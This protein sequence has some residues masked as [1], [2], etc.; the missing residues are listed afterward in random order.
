MFKELR[1]LKEQNKLMAG[2]GKTFRK[3]IPFFKLY[4]LYVKQYDKSQVMIQQLMQKRQAFKNFIEMQEFCENGLLQSFLIL[5]VQ[6]VPRYVL[7]LEQLKQISRENEEGLDDI[8]WALK[9]IKSV[10]TDINTTVTNWEARSKVVAIQAKFVGNKVNLLTPGRYFIKDGPL[11]KVYNKPGLLKKD[12][13]YHFFLFNDLLVYAQ[14]LPGLE[15]YNYKHSISVL[16]MEVADVPD[17]DKADGLKFA[18]RVQGK[19]SKK[20]LLYAQTQ[21]QKYDWLSALMPLIEKAQKNINTLHITEQKAAPVPDT[22]TAATSTTTT[23]AGSTTTGT[24]K[25]APTKDGKDNSSSVTAPAKSVQ[26][27]SQ[28][29]AFTPT[30]VK[31]APTAP[32]A[33]TTANTAAPKAHRAPPPPRKAGTG[34]ADANTT[35]AANTS[36]TVEATP[37]ESSSSTST[38][39]A[40]VVVGKDQRSPTTTDRIRAGTQAGVPFDAPPI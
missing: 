6:R 12:N 24:T 30:T 11:M 18:F 28:G 10:A 35:T 2:L 33:N 29:Q 37:P 21:P 40:P 20:L 9:E 19:D 25:D 3:F 13:E 7:L 31:T 23:P 27:V 34:P 32:V 8:V 39:A 14:R 26:P 1:E 5:P 4:T 38:P 22:T 16:G 36:T 17:S 15:F